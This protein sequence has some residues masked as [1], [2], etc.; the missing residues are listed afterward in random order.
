MF[1][2]LGQGL[3]TTQVSFKMGVMQLGGRMNVIRLDDRSLLIHSPVEPSSEMFA[4]V[5][6]LGEPAFIVAPN[7]WHHLHA[8]TWLQ[9]FPKAELWLAA[10]LRKKRKDLSAHGYLDQALPKA[11]DSH[12]KTVHVEGM[13]GFDETVFF[14]LPSKSLLITDMVLNVRHTSSTPTRLLLKMMGGYGHVA[15][16]WIHIFMLKDK[17]AA[18]RSF[19]EILQLPYERVVPCHGDVAEGPQLTEFKETLSRV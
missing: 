18:R 6:A 17:T 9:E 19:A 16:D 2:D 8:G 13:P 7:Q 1:Q 11:W 10:G 3:F 15:Q 4:A 5:R 12:L 14:H